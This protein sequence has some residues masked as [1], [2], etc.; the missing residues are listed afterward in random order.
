ML[1]E[2]SIE[3]FA[4][5]RQVRLSLGRGLNVL[6]GETGAGK[7]IVV[8]AMNLLVGG[9][10]LAEQ[11]RTGADKACIEGLF[12]CSDLPHVIEK[13]QELGLPVGEDGLL[14]LTREVMRGGKGACRV[15]GRLVPL[16]VYRSIG[17]LLVDL[18]GQHEHQSLLKVEN[19]LEMLDQFGGA[20]LLRKRQAVGELYSRL[21][22]LKEEQQRLAADAE[23]RRQRMDYLKHAISE[24]DTVNPRPGE[25]NELE[26]ERERLR[27]GERL[28]VLAAEITSE[29]FDGYSNVM[30]AYDLLSRASEKAEEMARYDPVME[31]VAASLKEIV[32]KLEDLLVFMRDY[33]ER[34]DFDK[35]HAAEIEERLYAVKN[36]MRKYGA[37]LEEV[38]AFREE[39]AAELEELQGMQSRAEEISEEYV[40]VMRRYEEAANELTALRQKKAAL[41]T[42]AVLSELH[43]LGME[44]ARFDISWEKRKEPSPMGY[45]RIE[46]LFSANPGE[47]LKPL[48]KIASGGELARLM[49]GL[50]VVLSEVDKIPTL[51]FDEIDAGIGGMTLQVVGEKLSAVARNKQ[52]LCVTHS[53]HIA[54]RAERHF[55]I[56]KKVIDEQTYTFVHQLSGEE[57]VRELARMLGGS[58]DE[59]I[60]RSHAERLLRQK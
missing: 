19:H 25:E 49:L 10:A 55:Y 24:I 14:V 31:N 35:V 27:H 53:P 36:L 34:V 6:T 54:G 8:D 50:R 58:A 41:F 47:P 57:R 23:K 28:A 11:V 17:E 3:N 39:A 48:V 15:N 43:S 37:T 22:H 38:C 29:L 21:V 26:R 45:D 42:A 60:T 20:E 1:L 30:P 9:R 44:K 51:V 4:L 56:E 33:R 5:I 52:V 40:E 32:F 7:S 13:L 12:D 46:F 16:A 59:E 2:I 18:H